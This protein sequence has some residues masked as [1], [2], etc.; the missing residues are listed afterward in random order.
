M[1][2]TRN[3]RRALLRWGQRIVWLALLIW[4]GLWLAPQVSAWTGIGGSA[5]PAPP[6]AVST[7]S[8]SSVGEEEMR[9]RVVLLSFWAT[10]CLPCRVEMPA[11]QKLHERHAEDG[12]LVL[13]MVT[14]GHDADAVNRFLEEHDITFPIARAPADLR[15][16]LGGIDR[17]PT[18]ILI[19][20]RGMIRHRVV[21]LFA[22]PAIGAAVRR[23]LNNS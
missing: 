9:G 1:S 10:W 6:I 22:P 20:R 12:L 23:F 4:I 19:D 18:T 21:G 3:T 11:L 16:A 14:D 5:E 7:W 15:T 13:G 8:G 17:L 2:L